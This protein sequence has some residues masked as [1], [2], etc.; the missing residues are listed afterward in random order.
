MDNRNSFPE[1]SP[2]T[3]HATVSVDVIMARMVE[4]DPAAV[5]TLATHHGSRI[6]GVV[7]RHLRVCGVDRIAK[8]DLDGLVLDAC[9]VLRDVA[10][11]WRVGGA[12]PWWWAEGRIRSVVSAW[13][14]VHADPLDERW[15]GFVGDDVPAPAASDDEPV[16][17]TFARLVDEVPLVGLVAEAC[18]AARVDELSLVCLL[19]YS[20]QQHQG[21]PSPAHTLAARYGVSPETLRKRISRN[22]AR[23]RTV[24]RSE[25]RFADLAELALV[26]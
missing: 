26:A 8:E 10:P 12:L 15:S 4:G 16:A 7:R 25:P 1:R 21:D 22:R 13:V 9:M 17:E 5:F 20:M 14:G 2:S 3:A 11:A 24:V 23:L 6:A 19:D 18:R